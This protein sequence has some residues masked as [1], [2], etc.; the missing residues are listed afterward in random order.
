MSGVE[1]FDDH[2]AINPFMDSSVRI[3]R[4]EARAEHEAIR[5]ALE[6]AGVQVVKVDAPHQ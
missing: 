4:V 2:A 1:W 5:T 6:S 3:D